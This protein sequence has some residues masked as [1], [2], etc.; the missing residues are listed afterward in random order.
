[1]TARRWS[2]A[3]GRGAPE[4][5]GFVGMILSRSAAMLIVMSLSGCREHDARTALADKC[6]FASRYITYFQGST[7][8]VFSTLPEHIGESADIG[9]WDGSTTIGPVRPPRELI[10]QLIG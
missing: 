8:M 3:G 10:V 7:K 1:M 6:V 9:G 4:D 2:G 5:G